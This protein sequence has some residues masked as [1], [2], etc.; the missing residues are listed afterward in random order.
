LIEFIIDKNVD[1]DPKNAEYP[2][3]FFADLARTSKMKLVVGGTNYKKEILG[4]EKLREFISQMESAGRV[5]PINSKLVDDHEKVIAE[6]VLSCMGTCPSECDDHH[7]FALSHVSKCMNIV[8]KEKR[9][10]TCRDKIRGVIGHDICP[11]LR[12]IRNERSYRDTI[13]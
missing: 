6:R 3:Y 2:A 13:R 8:T 1:M 7:I 11:D 10:A 5:R 12:V 4:K 9:M